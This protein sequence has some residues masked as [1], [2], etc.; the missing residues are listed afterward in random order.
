MAEQYYISFVG[1]ASHALQGPQQRLLN[2]PL[3]KADF[4]HLVSIRSC[5]S[6]RHHVGGY[7]VPAKVATTV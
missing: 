1:K 4:M 3:E 7:T 2:G 5:D 6:S